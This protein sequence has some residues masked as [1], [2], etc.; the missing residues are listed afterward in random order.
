MKVCGL[1]SKTFSGWVIGSAGGAGASGAIVATAGAMAFAGCALGAPVASA[2][3][4]VASAVFTWLAI[5]LRGFSALG[6]GGVTTRMTVVVA[7]R[8][9]LRRVSHAA[10][11]RSASSSTVSKPT[12]CR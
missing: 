10:P 2:V 5:G 7:I 6:L 4:S 12:L 1:T 8:L 9:W 3:L 11:R